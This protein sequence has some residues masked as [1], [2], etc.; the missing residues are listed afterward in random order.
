MSNQFFI[1]YNDTGP[2]VQAQFQDGTG[3]VDLTNA[4]V[5]FIHRFR[6]R[7]SGAISGSATI[8]NATSGIVQYQLTGYNAGQHYGMFKATLNN[9]Q[10]VSFPNQ[11]F[12]QFLVSKDLQN[13]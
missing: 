8:S 4:T 1:G 6:S 9:S 12:L 13:L 2:T 5:H 3:Y 11:G 10:Q 7:V